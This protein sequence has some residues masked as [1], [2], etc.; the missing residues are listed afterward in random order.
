M[1]LCV[2]VCVR[3]C[4]CLCEL[5]GNNL[6][7]FRNS[8]GPTLAPKPGP[9]LTTVCQ[10]EFTHGTW[11]SFAFLCIAQLHCSYLGLPRLLFPS[12]PRL[13]GLYFQSLT[14]FGFFQATFCSVKICWKFLLLMRFTC[15]LSSKLS[16]KIIVSSNQQSIS[17]ILLSIYLN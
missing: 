17:I 9:S 3:V 4:V 1:L 13:V 11:R 14:H 5:P 16:F 15:F 6:T 12:F 2:L 10:N 8:F 7:E